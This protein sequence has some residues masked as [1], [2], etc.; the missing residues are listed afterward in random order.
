MITIGTNTHRSASSRRL[1]RGFVPPAPLH[2]STTTSSSLFLICSTHG[3]L[4]AAAQTS[5]TIQKTCREKNNFLRHESTL[6]LS[7]VP[8]TIESFTTSTR[9]FS[10]RTNNYFSHKASWWHRH[11]FSQTV[12]FFHPTRRRKI[13]W[14][15]IGPSYIFSQVGFTISQDL[16]ILIVFTIVPNSKGG[17]YGLFSRNPS[18]SKGRITFCP[19]TILCQSR[20]WV[21]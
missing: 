4:L 15:G 3:N 14:N 18:I 13:C 16:G 5:Q 6:F 8:S 19:L 12:I 9:R 11:C 21:D 1:R 17:I 20:I 10:T 2:Q 7:S